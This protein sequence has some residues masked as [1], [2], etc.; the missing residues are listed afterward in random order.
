MGRI[1]L[2]LLV[3]SLL[4]L[5]P[6][7]VS[8]TTYWVHPDGTGDYPDIQ[9]ALTWVA[10]GDT[11][12][13]G[14]G[15]YTGPGNRDLD[16]GGKALLLASASGNP[17][18]CVLDAQGDASNWR[19]VFHIASGEDPDTIIIGLKITG[20]FHN[21]GGG[22]YIVYDS[23]PTFRDCIFTL[24]Y[25]RGDGAA[26]FCWENCSPTF[27]NCWFVDNVFIDYGAQNGGGVYGS[28]SSAQFTDCVF[29]G[30]DSHAGGGVCFKYGGSPS[31]TRCAFRNNN[32][33]YAGGAVALVSYVTFSFLD[34]EFYQNGCDVLG[35]G[36]AA[37]YVG[38][39]TGNFIGCSFVDNSS[40]E[41]SA[42][43]IT[44]YYETT[45]NLENSVIAFNTTCTAV[46]CAD[47]NQTIAM[48]CSDVFGNASN[49]SA[50][51][52]SLLTINGNI[53][54]DPRYCDLSGGD[55]GLRDDSPCLPGNNSCG[56]L[57]GVHVAGCDLST[58]ENHVRPATYTPVFRSIHPNP[59]N[60]RTTIGF[61]LPH[62]D[63]VNLR[64]FD[65]SGRLV[66]VLVDHE[67]LGAGDHTAHWNGRNLAGQP[68]AAGTY[69]CRLEI[70]GASTTRSLTLIK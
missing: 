29:S 51:L 70:P 49:G 48:V 59:F 56:V 12:L 55:L 64:I 32:A 8:A 34:C 24:N 39:S 30:H 46:A 60:P 11:V 20:G 35:A 36:G 13:L 3:F 57:M 43:V 68:V 54:E 66:R 7:V 5:I 53:S 1:S 4:T 33:E 37:V 58:V 14:D 10:A 19:R 9:G 52:D 6:A 45:V 28:G 61:T 41:E 63:K 25:S 2:S 47:T 44:A 40:A 65:L 69:L 26:V 42:G 67:T 27:T 15:V 21:D 50:C 23:S 31:F 16:F 38:G 17:H 62:S 22:A 18:E